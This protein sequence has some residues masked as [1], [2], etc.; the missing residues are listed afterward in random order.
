MK[1]Q[2]LMKNAVRM[3]VVA[4]SKGEQVAS[5]LFMHAKGKG[6]LAMPYKDGSM[7][8]DMQ[9][10]VYVMAIRAAREAGTFDGCV[11]VSE[12]WMSAPKEKAL[13][14]I[15]RPSLDPDRQEGLI[16]Y[17]YGADGSKCVYI[18]KI[19]RDGDKPRIEPM[20]MGGEVT[21]WLDDA[22]ED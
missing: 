12:A 14:G 10:M 2:D 18:A 15:I 5:T 19:F 22:F 1:A 17:A 13:V 9:Q 3:A 11:L 21:S 8:V 20:D 6:I 4:I 7:P 16:A